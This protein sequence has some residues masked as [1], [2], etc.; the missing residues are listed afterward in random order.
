MSART[1][2]KAYFE[3]GD[4]PTES[5]FAE[6]ID[7]FLNLTDDDT[8]NITEGAANLFLLAAERSK[9]GGIAAGAQV[10]PDGVTTGDAEA[11]IGTVHKLWTPADIAAAIAAQAGG[12]FSFQLRAADATAVVGQRIGFRTATS[13]GTITPPASPSDGD[14]WA[15]CDVSN[16]ASI[17][18]VTIAFNTA[19][20]KWNSQASNLVLSKDGFCATWC[21]K[22]VAYGWVLI[23][24]SID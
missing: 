18:N 19:G 9:L 13:N 1:T 15:I 17:N 4:I 14:E 8:D 5:Q 10:N 7:S 20:T 6:L 22:G 12:G 3:T 11:G 21:Y 16:N 24:G 2:L 23:S